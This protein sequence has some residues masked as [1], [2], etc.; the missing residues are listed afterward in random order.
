[1]PR[2]YDS[3]SN[4][5]DYCRRCFPKTEAK[6]YAIHGGGEGPDDR[7]DCFAYDAEHPDYADDPDMYRCYVCN[8][9]LGL[10][11]H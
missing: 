3:E 4:P 1:M 10:D 8:K 9:E 2:I 7:G 6:A 11:I 5:V